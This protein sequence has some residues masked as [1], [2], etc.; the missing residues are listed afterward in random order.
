M[1]NTNLTSGTI[2]ADVPLWAG[3][4]EESNTDWL[5]TP[6]GTNT[7]AGAVQMMIIDLVVASNTATVFDLADTASGTRLAF[8]GDIAHGAAVIAV[9]GVENRS[10]GHEDMTLVR[11]EGAQ[12]LFTAPSGVSGDTVRLTIMYR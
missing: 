1:A 4:L 3:V 8:Q 2:V 9:L 12:V 5:Q 10:G 11:G 6:I 7:A